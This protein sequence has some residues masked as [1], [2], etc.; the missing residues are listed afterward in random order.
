MGMNAVHIE[1]KKSEGGNFTS[2]H[3]EIDIFDIF[4]NL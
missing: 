4:M 2:L 1:F 3:N